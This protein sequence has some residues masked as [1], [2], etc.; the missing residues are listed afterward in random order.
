MK[1]IIVVCLLLFLIIAAS[2]ATL[3]KEKNEE[4]KLT[5]AEILAKV[6]SMNDAKDQSS[7]MK[8]ILIL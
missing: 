3:A 2:M 8:M 1:K 5:G 4:K 6:E 7:N